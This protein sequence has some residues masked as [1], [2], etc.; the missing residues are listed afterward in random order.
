LLTYDE[1]AALTR[2]LTADP[3][4]PGP[5]VTVLP[6][7]DRRLW[8]RAWRHTVRYAPEAPAWVPIHE[9]AHIASGDYGHG[10]AW[11][12]WAVELA[13]WAVEPAGELRPVA[14]LAR[15]NRADLGLK[16]RA[17]ERQPDHDERRRN[18]E[19]HS[20]GGVVSRA[21]SMS[22]SGQTTKPLP[23]E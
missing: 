21:S 9:L 7:R 17:G 10:S 22:H 23:A 8:G 16:R 14:H 5:A 2:A 6:L 12:A 15:V 4:W 19:R 13:G 18:V 20:H 3:R 1:L 11:R